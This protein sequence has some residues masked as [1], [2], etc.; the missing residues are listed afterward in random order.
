MLIP[1]QRKQTFS[2]EA[3]PPAQVVGVTTELITPIAE[4]KTST[5]TLDIA[6][7]W[8]EVE[9]EVAYYQLRVARDNTTGSTPIHEIQP[10]RTIQNL[11]RLLNVAQ[12][13]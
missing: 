1:S 4:S 2:A 13:A 5:V 3:L 9:A 12:P 8:G 10:V 7:A 6:V 11:L